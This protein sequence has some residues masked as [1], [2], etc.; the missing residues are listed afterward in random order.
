MTDDTTKSEPQTEPEQQQQPQPQKQPEE[1]PVEQPTEQ[2]TPAVPPRM[3]TMHFPRP[4]VVAPVD[5]GDKS[6][7]RRAIA[8]R[9]GPAPLPT[10]SFAMTLIV[11]SVRNAMQ[12]GAVSKGGRR[13]AVPAPPGVRVVQTT[14]PMRPE[15]IMP[16]MAE[17]EAKGSVPAEWVDYHA[18]RDASKPAERVVIYMHGGGYTFGS[19][20]M[21]RSV[22]W[23]LAKHGHARVLSLDYRLA[24]KST[25]PVAV[26]DAL[27]AYL[28]LID[29]P[30]GQPKYE[31][32]QISFSGDSAGGGLS[33]GLLL[34][35]RD[36]G[37][38]MPGAVVT[39]SPWLDLSL[40]L[41]ARHIN[42]AYD[43]LPGTMNQTS[44]TRFVPYVKTNDDLLSPYASPMFARDGD[45]G[46]ASK[47][48]LPPMLIQ[49]G[50][51]E[52]VRDDGIVFA[53][54]T[55]VGSP[56]RVE[57]YE[58]GVHVFQ[59]F[60]AADGFAREA[61]RRAGVFIKEQTGGTVEARPPVVPGTVWVRANRRL[62]DV[63]VPDPMGIIDDAVREL[64]ARGVWKCDLE[65]TSVFVVR[66]GA[67]LDR[68]R[69]GVPTARIAAEDAPA[70]IISGA[71]SAAAA[72]AVVA[73]SV[74]AVAD[75]NA[76]AENEVKGIIA[77]VDAEL[78]AAGGVTGAVDSAT[79]TAV[80]VEDAVSTAVAIAAQ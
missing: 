55:F 32:H 4:H 77:Q 59:I 25:F 34:Y 46:D 13:V 2:Q 70:I 41:P 6:E 29:P 10:W 63:D 26:F 39:F 78:K 36:N 15:R 68:S 38:P 53:Y 66:D 49:V 21:H 73:A 7:A 19:P 27:C 69:S 28:H 80:D 60:A 44:P 50:D 17:D 54:N 37:I 12:S 18:Y 14:V 42:E 75:D 51:A 65:E 58:D 40:S 56:I 61:L 16:G 74:T 3:P 23:R 30:A 11:R 5:Q 47:P 33:T 52:R 43:Y 8:A 72:D 9:R 62:P 22:T 71:A 48:P 57:I 64:V 31:P 1:Q 20:G 45:G 35:C 76:E 79:V 24:P 67:T